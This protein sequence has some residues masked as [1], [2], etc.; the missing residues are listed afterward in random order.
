L[1]TVTLEV[2]KRSVKFMMEARDEKSCQLNYTELHA[3]SYS[4]STMKYSISK[5]SSGYIRVINLGVNLLQRQ[6][7]S[8]TAFI[9]HQEGADINEELSD[10][11]S[12]VA[13]FKLDTDKTDV[14][15]KRVQRSDGHFDL[16]GMQIFLYKGRMF[17]ERSYDFYPRDAMLARSL[18]QRRVRLSVCPDV[19][20]TPVLCLAERKQD[21]E[22]Y[23]I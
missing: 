6:R 21:R 12:S 5:V 17:A 9:D 18:R 23:T 3:L 22:M 7:C 14:D 15:K 2:T 13:A 1:F 20:H 16:L 8:T 10:R 4:L 19:R 11:Q